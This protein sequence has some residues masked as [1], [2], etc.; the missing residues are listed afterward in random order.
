M[1]LG[2]RWDGG[3]RGGA[4]GGR[5]RVKAVSRREGGGKSSEGAQRVRES[6]QGEGE[7]H[8]GA[9]FGSQGGRSRL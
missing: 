3:Q 2:E 4:G 9:G 5:L 8:P 7:G 6:Q 1:L